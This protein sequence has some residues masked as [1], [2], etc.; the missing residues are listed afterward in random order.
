MSTG[1]QGA[2]AIAVADVNTN[3][4]INMRAGLRRAVT[5]LYFFFEVFICKS[6]LVFVEFC[7][8]G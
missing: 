8:P 7:A 6:F 4:Q 3:R 1:M 2:W 5:K